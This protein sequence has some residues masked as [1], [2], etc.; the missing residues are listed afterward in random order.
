MPKITKSAV[1]AMAPDPSRETYLWDSSLAG[2][3]VRMMPNG[4]ASFI[5]KY[6]TRSGAAR[7]M[8]IARVGTI[9][10]DEA[11]KE[12]IKALAEVAKGG[13]PSTD[14]KAA[15]KNMK[16][17]E[18]ADRF[19]ADMKGGWKE[20]TYLANTSQIETHIK[21]LL[22]HRDAVSLTYTDVTK[23]LADIAA[24]KTAKKR[25]GRGG[26]T[27][28]GKGVAS[29]ALV[30]LG[31]ILNHGM[32]LDVLSRNV[33]DG[34]KKDATGK[35]TR[36]LSFDDLKAL[37]KVLEDSPAEPASGVSAIRFLLL[38]GFRRNEALTLKGHYCIPEKSLVSLPDTKTGAQM[39]VAGKAAL[40]PIW[41]SWGKDAWVFPADRGE[42]HFVGLPKCLG[43]ICAEAGIEGVSAH[44]LRHTFA[45]VAA[46]L[47]YSELTI[48]GLLGHAA[49]SVTARYAHVAD[50]ALVSAANRVSNVIARALAG[51][52]VEGEF[53]PD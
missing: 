37:G 1:D 48:A 4:T 21:P 32:R 17:A 20:N 12:A 49:G 45:A 33:T 2:F 44:T 18:L 19:V 30:I 43:R 8:V 41:M 40:D 25:K 34:A 23:M 9:T 38:T 13:D 53:F 11:R 36:F 14:R 31:A 27:T 47:G 35:R 26:V 50:A 16:V 28:G 5:L 39:R 29:R 51:E 22:G 24:G 15:R 42:G 7:K 52:N 10:P 3:G 46:T 6:R